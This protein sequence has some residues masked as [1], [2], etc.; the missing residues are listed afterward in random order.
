[1]YKDPKKQKE[2]NREWRRLNPDYNKN[3]KR[4]KNGVKSNVKADTNCLVF[5][6]G[7]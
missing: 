1:M 6:C 2:A 3:Y 4:K 5:C 7:F